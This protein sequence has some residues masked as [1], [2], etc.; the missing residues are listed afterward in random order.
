MEKEEHKKLGIEYFNKTWE[1]IDLNERTEEQVLQMI[2][3]AH[4]SILHWTL[5]DGT[6]LNLARGEWVIAKVY[7][8]LKIGESAL[9]HGK[10]SLHLIEKNK[11]GDF[12]LVF[13]YEAISNAYKHLGNHQKMKIYLDLGYKAL[14]GV[15]NENDKN[16]SKEELDKI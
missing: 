11:Y 4:A 6:D 12:D 9:M 14:S 10:A 15:P 2:H 3:Y 5:A 8:T 7:N 1:Y 13:A 16:Y